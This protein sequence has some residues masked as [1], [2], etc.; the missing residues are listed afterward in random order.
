MIAPSQLSE[1]AVRAFVNAVNAGDRAA[2]QEALTPGATMSDDG[3]DRD[4]AQ[5]A[6]KEIFSSGGH[7]DVETEADGGRSL[8][9]AYRNDTWGEMRTAWRFEVTADG[10]VS[11]FETGQA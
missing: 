11:R 7:M 2:F 4:V 10:R 9:V 3:S 5:W 8:V 6:D 1:P